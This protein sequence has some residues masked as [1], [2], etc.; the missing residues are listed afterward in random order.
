M[1]LGECVIH[2]VPIPNTYKDLRPMHSTIPAITLGHANPFWGFCEQR[3]F[4]AVRSKTSVRIK[5]RRGAI[6]FFAC[7]GR[8]L[9]FH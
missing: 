7:Y 1:F 4:V 2:P 5:K 8:T 9:L 3:L 6:W